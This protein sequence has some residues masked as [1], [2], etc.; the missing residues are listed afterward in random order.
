MTSVKVIKELSQL[1]GSMRPDDECVAYISKPAE[2]FMGLCFQSHFFKVLHEI[3]CNDWEKQ[4]THRHTVGFLVELATEAEKGGSQDRRKS[5]KIA[6][7]KCRLRRCRASSMGTME[8]RET[9]SKL[10]RM[11]R[12][13]AQRV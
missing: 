9:T 12:G 1:A 13:P 2:G 3:V 11:S 8:K 4:Q 7:S 10:T 5:R 6:S